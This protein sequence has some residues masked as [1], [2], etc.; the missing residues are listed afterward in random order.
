MVNK[1]IP[2]RFIILLVWLMV[3]GL[4]MGTVSVAA[5]MPNDDAVTIIILEETA[6]RT[7]VRYEFGDFTRRPIHR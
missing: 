6:K 4:S 1:S 7:V 3:F 5:G 2:I